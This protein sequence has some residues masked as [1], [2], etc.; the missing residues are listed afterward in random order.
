MIL[1]RV[2]RFFQFLGLL[3]LPIAIAGNLAREEQI[4]LKVSLMMSAAGVAI[5]ALGWLIQ[6]AARKP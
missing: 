3:I 2:G 5:F 4:N 1:Y 6:Q